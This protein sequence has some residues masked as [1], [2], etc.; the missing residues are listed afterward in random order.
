[1]KRWRVFH[2]IGMEEPPVKSEPIRVVEVRRFGADILV[3][4]SDGTSVIYHARFLYDMRS[5]DG[6][7]PIQE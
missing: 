5:H 2:A 7:V 4:F 3:Y 6:N 1:M